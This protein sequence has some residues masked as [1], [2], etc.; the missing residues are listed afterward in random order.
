MKK[1]K[2]TKKDEKTKV[3]KT[4]AKESQKESSFACEHCYKSVNLHE[5][6]GT[7]HRNH[8]PFCLW[9]KHVDN[10]IGDRK[11]SCC[12]I[13]EPVGLTLRKEA[14]KKKYGEKGEKLG[15][16]MIIHLCTL[17]GAIRINRI[18]SDDDE[19]Q[20]SYIFEK[21]IH[22]EEELLEKIKDQKIDL[23]LDKDIFNE[24]MFGNS[25]ID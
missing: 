19:R 22:L 13:M 5:Q 17:C 16:I 4:N 14:K 15:E 8:C 21:S 12:G 18:A 7:K 23:L 3:K 25:F 1:I 24:K 2:K 11:S 6:I 9:S 10:Q 20:I